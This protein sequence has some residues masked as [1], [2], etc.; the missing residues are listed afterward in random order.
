MKFGAFWYDLIKIYISGFIM[1]G[2]ISNARRH[3]AKRCIELLN[4]A[5]EDISFYLSGVRD[6]I[7]SDEILASFFESEDSHLSYKNVFVYK[8]GENI[9]GAVCAYWGADSIKYNEPLMR[10]FKRLGISR[11]ID[12]ECFE[13]EFYIDSIAVDG[14]F[15]KQGIATKLINHI[16]EIAKQRG[17]SKVALLVDEDKQKTEAFYGSLGF[18]QDTTKI[19]NSHKYH[20]MI[21][22]IL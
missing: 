18:R 12:A 22:E 21:K 9:V 8:V 14:N 16:C 7:Q 19:V 4:L 20:H 15:R 1:K 3:D 5:L 10:N 11:Q 13:D 2:V 6:K 17:H